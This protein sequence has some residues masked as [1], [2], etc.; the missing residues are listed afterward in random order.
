MPADV[1]CADCGLLGLRSVRTREIVEAEESVREGGGMPSN[2]SG[3]FY[4]EMPICLKR[5]LNFS[6]VVGRGGDFHGRRAT[7][8]TERREC[9]EFT[10]WQ[11]GFT[12]KEHAEMLQ[13][14]VRLEW[15]KQREEADR[16]WRET[17]AQQAREW[18]KED[19]AQEREDRNNERTWK[20]MELAVMGG[21][22][23][24]VSAVVQIIAAYIS[25]G[26]SAN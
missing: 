17:Q 15:Q 16:A 10:D 5:V 22:V 9:A 13:E 2:N 20:L 7:V 4:D 19:E 23:T 21:I 8:L 25:R 3:W 26:P 18:R 24:V 11:Q 14:K 6:K 12:P 1:R